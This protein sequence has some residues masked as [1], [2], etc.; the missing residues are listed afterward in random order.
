MKFNIKVLEKWAQWFTGIVVGAVYGIGKFPL[1]LTGA[2]IKHIANALWLAAVPVLV[3]WANP[4]NDF[5]MTV[6]K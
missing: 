5:T 4:R 6:K 3:K 2:D 1:D